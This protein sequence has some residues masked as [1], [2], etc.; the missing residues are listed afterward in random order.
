MAAVAFAALSGIGA[1]SVIGFGADPTGVADSSAA[2][3]AADAF[4]G[5]LSGG[6]TVVAPA[7]TYK[8][9]SG[10]EWSPKVSFIGDSAGLTT[11]TSSGNVTI[12]HF[13][14][15]RFCTG[16]FKIIGPQDPAKTSSIGLRTSV[17]L[18]PGK[19]GA[20]NFTIENIILENCY[21]GLSVEGS[22]NSLITNVQITNCYSPDASLDCVGA[23]GK[24]RSI[25]IASGFGNGLLLRTHPTPEL[26]MAAPFL[27]DLE[28]FANGGWGVKVTQGMG[29]QLTNGFLNNDSDGEIL[30]DTNTLAIVG[31]ISNC[32]LQFAGNNPFDP[33][34]NPASPYA[35]SKNAPGIRHMTG[36]GGKFVV[37]NTTTFNNAGNDIETDGG[38]VLASSTFFS[39]G[40]GLPLRD[41]FPHVPPDTTSLFGLRTTVGGNVVAGTVI[42]APVQVNGDN[43]VI[44]AG[45][46]VSGNSPTVPAF[47]VKAG[48]VNNNF[49]GLVV[50]QSNP[51]GVNFRSH[52][53][54]S[55]YGGVQAQGGTMDD[56]GG[57]LPDDI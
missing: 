1:Y 23:Q 19:V 26:A 48:S 53:T 29:L 8:L 17:R 44:G 52:S 55:Y 28:T 43:N 31:Q 39:P 22:A 20:Q 47:E 7:G 32:I 54:S 33:R 21:V 51:A 6:G 15:D 57:L 50:I 40:Q 30:L 36:S 16:G 5:A 34:D 18:A 10:V 42:N 41:A 9:T 37:T 4:V 13:K 3:A 38:L 35:G 49:K 11:L 45:T 56:A 46:V 24:W 2:F 14:H 25:N 12:L 27:S